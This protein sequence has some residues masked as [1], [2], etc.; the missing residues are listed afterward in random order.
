MSS[1]KKKFPFA[2]RLDEAT[3]IMIKYPDRVPIIVENSKTSNLCPIDKNK[4]LVP[5]DLTMSQFMYVIRKRISLTQD[6]GI[7]LLINNKIMMGSMSMQEIYN[8]EKEKDGFL[9]IILSGESVFG[10]I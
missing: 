9:Y 8:Q 6:Q 5:R 1:F 2:K 4:F 3:R 10:C 7:F